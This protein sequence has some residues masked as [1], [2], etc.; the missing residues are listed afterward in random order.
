MKHTFYIFT[1]T[2]IA[3]LAGCSGGGTTE[4]TNTKHTETNSVYYW[5]TTFSP[6]SAE[7]SFI[8][9]HNIGRIYLRMFDVV[10]D[11]SGD[12]NDFNTIPNATVRFSYGSFEGLDSMEFVPTVYITLDAMKA[13]KGNEDALAEL[14]VQRVAN[15]CSYNE[16]PNV[17]ELQLDCDWTTST[18]QSFYTLCHHVKMCISNKNLPWELSST[19]RLHQ[20]AQTPPPVARGVLM[21]Y[22]TGSFDNPDSDNS[23]ID[24]ED[25]EPYL[26]H[27]RSYPLHLDVAYP[28]YS[29]QLL[30]RGRKF[31][32]LLGRFDTADSTRFEPITDTKV[33][34]LK[35]MAYN[36]R[37]INQGDIIR[38]ETSPV[39]DILKIKQLIDSK[40]T[41]RKHSNIL[42][43]LSTDNL[44]KYSSNEIDSI[45]AF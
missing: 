6:D 4:A 29:W 31:I 1:L 37:V 45:Y 33:R 12:Y 36:D 8:N 16:I 5:R 34:V 7:R 26:K 35:D 18:R 32:G 41:G 21:V 20:L 17:R 24:M 44:S 22:N 14:I 13:E 40:L 9:K 19:I 43:H 38:T 30:F 27:L 10:A 15:M 3:V 39:A 2:I 28:T 11:R 42:Y 23:I 25:V